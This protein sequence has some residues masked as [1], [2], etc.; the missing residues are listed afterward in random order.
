MAAGW[1]KAAHPGPLLAGFRL[2]SYS[3]PAPRSHPGPF[4]HFNCPPWTTL[5]PCRDPCC[6]APKCPPWT[7]PA[8]GC[9][10]Q[11]PAVL[12][13]P[14]AVLTQPRP[15]SANCSRLARGPQGPAQKCPPWTIPAPGCEPS[16]PGGPS[17]PRPARQVLTGP[18]PPRLLRL[19]PSAPPQPASKPTLD[20]SAPRKRVTNRKNDG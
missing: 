4:F 20:H 11:P 3:A 5:Q 16:Q 15:A 2:G 14:P 1:Q 12:T 19:A 10:T 18:F 6:C 9:S 7:I 13:Q 17:R 8:P